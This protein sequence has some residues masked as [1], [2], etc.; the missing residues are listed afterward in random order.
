MLDMKEEQAKVS[1]MALALS[2][3][4]PRMLDLT[5]QTQRVR[6]KLPKILK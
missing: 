3:Q 4:A 1:T 2:A 5:V 6:A